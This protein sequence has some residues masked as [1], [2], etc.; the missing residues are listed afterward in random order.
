WKIRIWEVATGRCAGTLRGHKDPVHAVCWSADGRLALS[1]SGQ[2]LTRNESERILTHGELKLWR[3]DTGRAFR[4]FRE[5]PQAGTAV[6]LSA[7]GRWALSA[8]GQALF[9]QRDGHSLRSGR[10]QLW[11]VSSGR[12][13]RTFEGHADTVTAVAL[14][15]DGRFALSGSLDRTGK[16]W[17]LA[18]GRCLRTFEGHADV[19]QAAALRSGGRWRLPASPD[20]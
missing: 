20:G 19:G 14:T 2:F 12:C 9:P 10:F 17:Q 3:L 5:H 8:G 11:E 15:A 13:L 6:A 18:D 7:D 1:G 4:R 16:V